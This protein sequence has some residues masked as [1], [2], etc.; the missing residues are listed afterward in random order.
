[1]AKGGKRDNAGRKPGS[2]NKSNQEIKDLIDAVAFKRHGKKGLKPLI[3]ALFESA[4]GV[5]VEESDGK[6]G[7]NVHTKEPN[8]M[9]GKVILE[10]RWGKP[11]EQIDVNHSGGVTIIRDNIK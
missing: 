6:G 8:V 9:A 5:T 1:M 2:V 7:V 10:Y 11:K 3:M 4:E